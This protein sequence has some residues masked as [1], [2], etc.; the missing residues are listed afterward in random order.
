MKKFERLTK[1]LEGRIRQLEA[2]LLPEEQRTLRAATADSKSSGRASRRQR[3][4]TLAPGSMKRA[5]YLNQI[6]CRSR[7]GQPGTASFGTGG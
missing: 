6:Y 1:L 2:E 7:Q 5:Q 3:R 4:R